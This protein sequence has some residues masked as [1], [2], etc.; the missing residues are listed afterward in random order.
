MIMLCEMKTGADALTIIY[1]L[2]ETIISVLETRIIR[3]N[4]V[5]IVVIVIE[6][7][8]KITEKCFLCGA[9][10]QYE[11]ILE[12]WTKTYSISHNGTSA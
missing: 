11:D 3:E 10:N 12:I 7:Q 1:V 6:N 2:R 9:D 8:L 4:L 5:H